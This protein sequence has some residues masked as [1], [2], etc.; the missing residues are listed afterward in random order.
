MVLNI[1]TKFINCLVLVVSATHSSF[2]V[3]S[4]RLKNSLT[5]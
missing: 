3:Y 5:R 1:E 2:L 4:K